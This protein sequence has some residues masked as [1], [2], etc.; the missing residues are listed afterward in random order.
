MSFLATQLIGFGAG[1]EEPFSPF[2]TEYTTAQSTTVS[3][4]AGATQV[5]IECIGGGGNGSSSKATGGGGGGA[6]S[7]ITVALDGTYTGVWLQVGIAGGQSQI[8]KN[9]SLGTDLCKALAGADGS[10]GGQGGQSASGL[11]DVKFSGGNGASGNPRGGGGA[12][13]PSGNGSN[14]SGSTGGAGGGSPAGSGGNADAAGNVHGGGGGYNGT[15][16]D[17]GVGYVKLAWS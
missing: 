6:Y 9:S 17:G 2:S 14:A 12:A 16:R 3:K 10:Q 11:G 1:G 7:K 13:G 5:I 15:T 4:P 8:R